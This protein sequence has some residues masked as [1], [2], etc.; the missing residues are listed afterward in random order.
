M[1]KICPVMAEAARSEIS[2]KLT[3]RVGSAGQERRRRDGDK[4]DE[5]GRRDGGMERWSWRLT[6]S[7]QVKS[8]MKE[9]TTEEI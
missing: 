6:R 9:K 3:L 1:R 7:K 8:D 5:E 2:C 4:G